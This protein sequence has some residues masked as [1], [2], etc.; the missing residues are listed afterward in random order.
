VDVATPA[1]GALTLVTRFID[2]LLLSF[3]HDA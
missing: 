3:L 1:V 2:E